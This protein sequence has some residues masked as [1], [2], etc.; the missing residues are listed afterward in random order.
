MNV[1]FVVRKRLDLISVHPLVH[2]VKVLICTNS[3]LDM[4][5]FCFSLSL[6]LVAFFRRNARRSEV[7]EWNLGQFGMKMLS[8]N[9]ASSYTLSIR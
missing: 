9:L 2:H 7:S 8:F 1:L 5:I 6:S 3:S 4:A